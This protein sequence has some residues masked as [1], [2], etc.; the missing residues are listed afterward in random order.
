[1]EDKEASVRIEA[2]RKLTDLSLLEKIALKD[3]NSGV[4]R[5]AMVGIG[6]IGLK[7]DHSEPWKN[8]DLSYYDRKVARER[9]TSLPRFAME[10]AD[11]GVRADAVS[12]LEDASLLAKIAVQDNDAGV[13]IEAVR[14]L[15]Y[16]SLVDGSSSSS[17]IEADRRVVDVCVSSLAKTAEADKDASVR[18]EAVRKLT[19]RSLLAVVDVGRT[20]FSFGGPVPVAPSVLIN[21]VMERIAVGDTDASVRREALRQ[22]AYNGNYSLLR[23]IAAE[24]RDAGVR[25]AAVSAREAQERETADLVYKTS[26]AYRLQQVATQVGCPA[27]SNEPG[28]I[29]IHNAKGQTI[30]CRYQ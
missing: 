9:L 14:R 12:M 13:R 6:F 15:A 1:M 8:N 16:L 18:I 27:T 4:R 5:A 11:A 20:V 21:S 28:I 10:A 3:E 26:A 30:E 7:T 22:L 25:S 17:E 19:D 24:D 23:K 29:V 2:V